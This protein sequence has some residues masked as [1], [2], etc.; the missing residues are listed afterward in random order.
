MKQLSF[1]LFIFFLV[2]LGYSQSKVV[3][4]E[5]IKTVILRS[6]TTNLYAP[7]I[8]LNDRLVLSFDD[9]NADEHDYTYK[10]VH[11]DYD[12]NSSNL[13]DSEFI[14]GYAEDRIR[15]F[16]NSFNTLQPYTHYSLTIPNE[17]TRLKISG[18]YKIYVI[19]DYDEV[20]FERKFVVFE[21]KVTVGVTVY[22][23][24]DISTIDTNQS[25]QFI[26]NH[27]D[28]RINNP[29][30]EIL[31]VVLQNNNWQTAIEGLKPQFYRGT[32]LLYKYNKET[33]FKAGN[34]FL[35]LDTKSI[36]NT[37]LNI[38]KVE[39]GRD[40][41]HAYLYTNEERIDQPYTL[42][43][44]INGNFVVRTLNGGNSDTDADY[45]WVHFS[46]SCLEDLD[47]KDV[48]ISGNFNNWELNDTNKLNYNEDTGLYEAKLLLKQGFYNYQFVT[49]NQD[50]V[51]SNSDIDGSFYQTENDYTVLVYYKKYGARYTR[52]IGVGY[53]NSKKLNN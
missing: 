27:P 25:V 38:A 31:P 52:V 49:K 17:D 23:S 6:G 37:T 9:L 14:D 5:N 48:Y 32:Q 11:C 22:K 20:V 46:L 4:P 28:F 26:I 18:N 44:D 2:Q 43:E 15:D 47:G 50:G 51:I 10:I 8:S 16:E 45:G 30:E 29:K 24:R 13:S 33:S 41:Y 21:S 34:E 1:Y 40:L 42:L 35:Y 3:D 19:N 36:R 53:G 12:W 39:L 7:I